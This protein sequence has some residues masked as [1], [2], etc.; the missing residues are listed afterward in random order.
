[1]R[2]CSC[3]SNIKFISSR[4]RV[5]S[6]IYKAEGE[7]QKQ[8]QVPLQM[9]TQTTKKKK[10]KKLNINIIVITI[11][12]VIVIIMPQSDWLAKKLKLPLLVDPFQTMWCTNGNSF[13]FKHTTWKRIMFKQFSRE[14]KT[15]DYLIYRIIVTFWFLIIF[16]FLYY[17][18]QIDSMLLCI[19]SVIHHRRCENVVRTSLMHSAMITL[20]ATFLLLPHFDIICNQVLNR[21][22]STC[23]L[24]VNLRWVHW[25]RVQ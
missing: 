5:I 13:R 7:S 23:S 12:P 1:M 25:L 3:H 20:C 19:C 10:K 15:Q 18:K 9:A 6:S 2:Y 4:H 11:K 14:L 21:C 17:T 22:T 24:L 16:L 8:E